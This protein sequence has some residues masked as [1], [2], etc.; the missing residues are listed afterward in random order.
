MPSFGGEVKLS[1]PCRK[2]A[3]CKRT[4]RF[5][6][7]LESPGKID[8]QFLA[9]FRPSLTEISHVAWHGAPL[10]ITDGTKGS[11]QRASSLRPRCFREVDPETTTHIYL[12]LYHGHSLYYFQLKLFVTPQEILQGHYFKLPQLLVTFL[13]VTYIAT[14]RLFTHCLYEICEALYGS[15]AAA[16][17]I[18]VNYHICLYDTYAK[19]ISYK[20][21][22]KSDVSA[23]NRTMVTW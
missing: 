20:F 15:T 18:L 19:Y 23:P 10:E 3:A 4:L 21:R 14:P 22:W 16:M 6:W 2:F 17:W 11:A 12:S 1:V 5:T 13:W 8:W 9:Q 7:K